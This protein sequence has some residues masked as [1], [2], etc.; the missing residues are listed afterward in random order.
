M[1]GCCEHLHQSLFLCP[2]VI[3]LRTYILWGEVGSGP[4]SQQ[5]ALLLRILSDEIL[6][7]LQAIGACV[8]SSNPEVIELGLGYNTAGKL[9]A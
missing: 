7:G 6:G 2:L 4:Q 8:P 5:S 3:D 9:L 1:L